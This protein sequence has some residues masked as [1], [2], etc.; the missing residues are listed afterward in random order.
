MQQVCIMSN[1]LRKMTYCRINM[2]NLYS[3]V[4]YKSVNIRKFFSIQVSFWV[5]ALRKILK[6]RHCPSKITFAAPPHSPGCCG[7]CCSCSCS[8]TL[9]W[10]N[11]RSTTEKIKAW[12][13][14]DLR[15]VP[16]TWKIFVFYESSR[17]ADHEMVLIF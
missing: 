5:E 15:L 8:K 7:S 4:M 3:H 9:R 10:R 12:Y 6:N 14:N 2:L 16:W 11:S 13:S 17:K 1:V